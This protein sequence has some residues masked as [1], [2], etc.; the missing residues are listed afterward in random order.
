MIT[1]IYK[2]DIEIWNCWRIK[3]TSN[4]YVRPQFRNVKNELQKYFL[5]SKFWPKVI[6]ENLIY[7]VKKNLAFYHPLSIPST[8]SYI[9]KAIEP[10]R[11]I[12][13]LIG[14][15]PSINSLIGDMAEMYF[16]RIRKSN[17]K[18]LTGMGLLSMGID[19]FQWFIA[20]RTYI[21]YKLRDAVLELA[22]LS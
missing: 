18:I 6:D 7:L 1:L 2:S 3:K 14:D 10:D 15:H 8:P 9:S 21:F 22:S 13:F 19:Y 12:A 17:L 11:L 16:F 20:W 5:K 4:F